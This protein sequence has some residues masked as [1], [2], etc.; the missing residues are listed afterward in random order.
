MRRLALL[1][2]IATGLA[3]APAAP[4]VSWPSGHGLT[5]TS[6]KQLNPRL[7]A[8][9]VKTAALPDPASVHLLPRPPDLF[10]TAL[11]YSGAPDIYYDPDAR[12]GAK[13]VINA[14]ELGLTGESP[15]TFFGDQNSD[16][17]N[18]AAHDPATLAENLRWTRMYM[19]W[20]NGQNGPF[21]SGVNPGGTGIEAA[22]WR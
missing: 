21:D 5:I 7:V 6:V 14:T 2:V 12:A 10:A 9:T 11:G 3:G 15:D 17:I 18:W 22:I 16:G 4:A 1:G 20:G 19:Y 8:L 13:A